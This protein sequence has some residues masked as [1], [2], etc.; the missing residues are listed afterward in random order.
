MLRDEDVVLAHSKIVQ[1]EQ[2][3]NEIKLTKVQDF[4]A[5][6]IDFKLN[7]AIEELIS[8][9]K[10]KGTL[11]AELLELILFDLIKKRCTFDHLIG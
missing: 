8:D 10:S 11:D 9:L 2:G 3:P 1:W 5:V 6:H 4:I 7:E